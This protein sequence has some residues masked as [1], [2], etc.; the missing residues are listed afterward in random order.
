MPQYDWFSS[1]EFRNEI[2]ARIQARF[3]D[4]DI[5]GLPFTF[6][7]ELVRLAIENQSILEERLTRSFASARTTNEALASVDLIANTA[8]KI[9][10]DAKRSLVTM[11]D[12]NASI[13][14]TFCTIWPFCK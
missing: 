14:L 6:A 9:T 4:A 1:N 8:I 10:G 2:Y 13:K 5:E 3:K 7:T 11:D 12:L